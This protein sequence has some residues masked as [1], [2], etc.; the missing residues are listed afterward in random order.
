MPRFSPSEHLRL[1][2]ARYLQ[3]FFPSRLHKLI[4]M[5]FRS[6]SC[7]VCKERIL[8][9]VVGELCIFKV[10]VQLKPRDT[11]QIWRHRT[12]RRKGSRGSGAVAL[13]RSPGTWAFINMRYSMGAVQCSPCT[14]VGWHR[15]PGLSCA[16]GYHGSPLGLI[17]FILRWTCSM[18]PAVTCLSASSKPDGMTLGW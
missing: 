7:T 11:T 12:R 5:I 16:H 10:D 14:K 15:F 8:R 3:Q 6:E 9:C 13:E 18:R 4:L 1:F 17:C 2:N